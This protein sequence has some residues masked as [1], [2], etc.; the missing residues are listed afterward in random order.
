MRKAKIAIA[1]LSIVLAATIVGTIAT[2]AY[3]APTTF[4]DM[5]RIRNKDRTRN[6][7]Q[8]KDQFMMVDRNCTQDRQQIRE[9]DRLKNQTCIL[10]ETSSS[11]GNEFREREQ[12]IFME[13]FRNGLEIGNGS[14][15]GYYYTHANQNSYQNN[16]CQGGQQHQ[17]VRGR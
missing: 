8:D 4:Q 1:L 14:Q 9:R 17:N 2:S 10:N 7:T 6:Q 15:T 13:Q 12:N 5:D 16:I 3:A 11:I